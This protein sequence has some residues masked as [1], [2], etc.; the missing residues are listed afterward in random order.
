MGKVFLAC[1]FLST[2]LFLSPGSGF[3]FRCGDGLVSIGDSKGKVKITCGPPTHMETVSTKSKDK[4][5][6]YEAGNQQKSK[7]K[8]GV[9]KTKA[10]KVEKWYYNCGNNDFIYVLTFTGGTLSAEDTE[11]YGKG[12]SDCGGRNR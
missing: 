1:V 2:I 11:G 3:G 10:E 7:T 6:T 8:V 9:R 5:T 12:K 4:V